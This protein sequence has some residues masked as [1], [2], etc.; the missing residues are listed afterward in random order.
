MAGLSFT[1]VST[2]FINARKRVWKPLIHENADHNE[3]TGAAARCTLDSSYSGP[4]SEPGANSDPEASSDSELERSG[5]S[6]EYD[7]EDRDS[8]CKAWAHGSCSEDAEMQD[9]AE[10]L[11]GTTS[12]TAPPFVSR[13]TS[14]HQLMMQPSMNQDAFIMFDHHEQ[15]LEGKQLAGTHDNYQGLALYPSA[16]STTCPSTEPSTLIDLTLYTAANRFPQTLPTFGTHLGTH[17]IIDVYTTVTNSCR[18]GREILDF[19][20]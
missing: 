10:D 7:L 18:P 17:N 11:A 14:P 4:G 19:L 5:R 6:T 3:L 16:F 2:W 12:W 13:A 9:S 20:F 15:P 8:P 1:Q